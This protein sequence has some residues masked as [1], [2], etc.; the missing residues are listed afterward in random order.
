MGSLGGARS[1]RALDAALLRASVHP[2][3]PVGLA[4][5]DLEDTA[6][7]EAWRGWLAR[8]W[9]LSSIVEAVTVASPVLAGRVREL[10]AGR[11]VRPAQVR[12]MVMSVAGYLVRMRGRATPFGVFAGVAALRFG[13]EPPEFLTGDWLVRARA[14]ARWLAEVITQ[15]ES[16]AEVRGG[17]RVV[18]NDL[19]SVRGERIVVSWGPYTSPGDR[20]QV[21]VRRGRAVETVLEAAGSPIRGGDL[22]EK[23]AAELPAASVAGLDAMI[24]QLLACGVLISGLRPPSSCGDGLAH[25]LACL[26]S[27]DLWAVEDVAA[28]ADELRGIHT[29]LDRGGAGRAAEPLR[30]R[31]RALSEVVEQPVTLDCRLGDTTVLPPHVAE[32]AEV[33]A[34]ALVRASP[35]QGGDPHMRDYHARFVERYGIDALVRVDQLIDPTAGLGFPPHY[36]QRD[37]RAGLDPRVS[38]RDEQL[39]VLAQQ[40]ALDQ[41]R[42]VE[43]DDEFL[44]TLAAEAGGP[45]RPVP[46]VEMCVEVH[47]PTMDALLGGAF[48]L[49]V[50]GVGRGAL[51][52]SGRF[53]DLL[54]APD[55]QRMIDQYA[56]LPTTVEGAV[57]AQLSFPALPRRV[58][59]V[60]RAPR[61]LA[62]TMSLAEHHDQVSDRITVGD[63]AVAADGDRLYVVSLS[64]RR[65]VEPVVANAAAR[66]SWPPLARLLVEIAR[67]GTAA[68][69]PFAWGA[70]SCLPYLP[71]VRYRRGVLCPARWRIPRGALPAAGAPHSAWVQAMDT[72]RE[73]LRLPAWV[74][75]GDADRLLH[76]DLDKPIDL[77]LLRT[78]LDRASTA[79]RNVLVTEAATPTDFGWA[80]GRA[81]E[82]VVPLAATIPPAQPPVAVTG[83]AALTLIGREH[84]VLPGER[85]LFAR[86]FGHPDHIDTIITNHLPRLLSELGSESMWWFIRYRDPRPHLR[87]RLH[88]PPRRYGHVVVALG[89][90]A[91]DLRRR[92]LVGELTLD[93]YRPETARYG[94]GA[95]MDAAEALFAADSAAARAQI[96]SLGGARHVF[97]RALTAASMVDLAVSVTGGRASGMGWL[98]SHR[99][100]QRA[101]KLV[102]DEVSQAIALAEPTDD[103][104]AVCDLPDGELVAEAWRARRRAADTYAR[105]LQRS[106]AALSPDSVLGSLM[107]LH[108]IRAIGIDPDGE[109][110]TE[111]TA[112]AVALAW[113]ARTDTPHPQTQHSRP[114]TR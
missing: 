96:H 75:V 70:A 43:L 77:A 31:M 89:A 12:R 19:V 5:P 27:L 34:D 106:P 57:T 6:R 104:A 109:Q 103:H 73:R 20:A 62:V 71:R 80:G 46:H 10:L 95:A 64:R 16:C 87:L 44:D 112:R 22:I 3:E 67:S 36:G 92:G 99:P 52:L 56:R 61:L 98:L 101:G 82:I 47:A 83:S 13:P 97:P 26:D 18:V 86:L 35:H 24:A 55:Q 94:A 8:V 2:G 54:A 42:Q 72:L 85:V 88:P 38:S 59:N 69:S 4:W 105:C 49:V 45:P 90:W 108:H 33:A 114:E 9:A 7:V 84:A 11:A 110:L 28:L 23:L 30:Q 113:S 48:T 15:L 111:R 29:Q 66:R 21:S 1:Y 50:R 76:L 65:V 91:A 93:T 100:G 25:V 74:S 32:V 102:R 51:A 60:A 78:H 53:V 63:L 68:V 79:A 37:E 14:D 58:Q 17:V 39:L 107:H 40:A 81:H 41:A